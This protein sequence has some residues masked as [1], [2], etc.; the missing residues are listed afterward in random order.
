MFSINVSSKAGLYFST[1]WWICLWSKDSHSTLS[2]GFL[3]VSGWLTGTTPFTGTGTRVVCVCKL[4]S[5][6]SVFRL[7][8]NLTRPAG[9]SSYADHL[10]GD[11]RDGDWTGRGREQWGIENEP[12]VSLVKSD[13]FLGLPT[14]LVVTGFLGW[15]T[16]SVKPGQS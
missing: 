3:L 16:F 1:L 4:N 11:G 5:Y 10:R 14:V 6:C 13:L 8:F 2:L 7:S 9:N 12:F 15:G